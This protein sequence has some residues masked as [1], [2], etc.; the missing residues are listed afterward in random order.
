M[1]FPDF[2]V[3][4]P[5]LRLRDE[6]SR[7]LG[8][9]SDGVIEYH[10]AD[11]VR[12]AGHSCP[13]VAAAWLGARAGLSTLYPDPDVLPERGGV[14]VS[15]PGAEDEGVNGVIGQV[16]T[17]VTG[18]AAGNGF[19][20]IGGNHARRNLL[21]YDVANVGGMRFRRHDTGDAVDVRVDVRAIPADPEQMPL[22]GAIL[23]GHASA[24]EY[25]RFGQLWQDRVRRLLER[26]DD[27]SVVQVRHVH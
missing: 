12:L 27:P 19:Q 13:T 24:A 18:A 26:A 4:V 15:L 2:F 9:T 23:E 17:L 3:Q 16:L 20:G 14:S 11:A 6:L 5:P 8:A 10:Y 21:H 1:A 22:L 25:H 7:L